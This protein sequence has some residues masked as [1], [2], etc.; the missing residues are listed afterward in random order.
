MLITFDDTMSIEDINKG[1]V[2]LDIYDTNCSQ[3][4]L[5]ARILERMEE[6]GDLEIPVYQIKLKDH[7]DML[8]PLDIMC[9]PVLV[10]LKDGK[11][12]GRLRGVHQ[13]GNIKYLIKK[14]L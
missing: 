13:P 2:L 4:V 11:E 7:L 5:L 9:F 12:V 8:E 10:L 14:A 6:E 1:P 3:C